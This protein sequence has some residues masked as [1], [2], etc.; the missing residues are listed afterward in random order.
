M[1]RATF[2]AGVFGM[3]IVASRVRA[4]DAQTFR[5]R[6]RLD[7]VRDKRT[8]RQLEAVVPDGKRVEVLDGTWD[9]DKVPRKPLGLF[10]AVTVKQ[11]AKMHVKGDFEYG[12][13]GRDAAGGNT[14]VQLVDAKT[15]IEDDFD[16]GV[17][18][19]YPWKIAGED[20]M[21]VVSAEPVAP[22]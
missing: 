8:V 16:A 3:V 20:Y 6:I 13:S 10:A 7:S 17:A 18:I 1:N 14:V 12:S 19:A 9:Y 21:L 22:K 11:G 15:S 4:A 5:V 2:V